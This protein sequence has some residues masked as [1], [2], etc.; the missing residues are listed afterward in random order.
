[1]FYPNRRLEKK[2]F[3]QGHK[4]VAGVDEVGRG[5]WAGPLVAA[6]VILNPEIKIRGIKDSKLLRQSD[7]QELSQQIISQAVSWSIGL[8]D[9]ATIDKFGLTKANDL[10]LQQAVSNLKIKPDYILLDGKRKVL[11]ELPTDAIIDGDYKITCIAAASIVAKVFRDELMSQL[12]EYYPAYG[13]KQ[14]KG[15]GTAQHFSMLVKYGPCRLHR[16]SF[17][18]M[19]NLV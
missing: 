5:A 1:M 6:A 2:L 10:A 12:D 15:Y 18:P 17:K 19:K 4:L 13:F 14:H 8:V 9:W 11:F 3:Y 7:R 16:R